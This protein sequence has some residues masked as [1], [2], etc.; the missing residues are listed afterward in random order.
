MK[1]NP[2]LAAVFALSLVASASAFARAP[3]GRPG[4]LP[5]PPPPSSSYSQSQTWDARSDL[6][7]LSRISDRF[8]RARRKVNVRELR[9]VDAD[10]QAWIAAEVRERIVGSPAERRRQE[11]LRRQY[12]SA[13]RELKSLNRKFDRRALVKREQ[14]IDDLVRLARSE[15]R[16]APRPPMA[17]R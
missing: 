6:R 11:A 10:L 15:L 1:K 5:P 17:R 7:E 13:S 12:L 3:V 8:E 4:P 16:P 2:L 14:L 9:A